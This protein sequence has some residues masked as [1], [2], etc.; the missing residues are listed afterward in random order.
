MRRRLLLLGF[1]PLAPLAFYVCSHV[2]AARREPWNVLLI[3]IDTLRADHLSAYG[4]PRETSPSLARFA[5]RGIL[6]EQAFSNAPKT[7][8]SHM[9]LLTGLLPDAHGICNIEE[10]STA[11]LPDGIPTLASIL[12]EHGYTT[13]ALTGGGEV[14]PELGFD[15]GQDAFEICNGAPRIF[16]RAEDKFVEYGRGPWCLFVHTYA[17]HDPYAPSEPYDKMWTDPKYAGHIPIGSDALN[18]AAGD[19]WAA[20]H[21]AFWKQVDR[22]SKADLNE[23]VG[24]YDGSIRM[25]DDL[26][27]H[28]LERLEALNRLDRTLV[29]IVGDHGEEFREHGRFLHER[30]YQEE[31]HVPLVIIPPDDGWMGRLNR[32]RGK[33]PTGVVSL[34]DVLPTVLDVLGIEPPSH[35]QGRS[36]LPVARDDE[37]ADRTVLSAWPGDH[38]Y[39]LRRGPWKLIWHGAS[40]TGPESQELFDL[41]KDPRETHDLSSQAPAVCDAFRRELSSTTLASRAFLDRHGKKDPAFDVNES[42][43]KQL[44]SLGYMGSEPANH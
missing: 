12:R 37:T 22:G 25:V 24:L 20:R 18:V 9:T 23:L 21:E 31:L 35:L 2:H 19:D 15:R 40:Q 10:G 11:A 30:V 5:Q 43:K 8:P 38:Y 34:V 27:G 32:L 36:V 1:V 17:V 4:Y 42:L 3:S 14:I 7:A 26:V 44:E 16:S 33:R 28:L 39:A 6:F 13:S 29:V 41:S